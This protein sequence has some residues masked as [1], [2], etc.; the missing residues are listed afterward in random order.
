MALEDEV[1]RHYR[2]GALEPA[3]LDALAAAGKNLDKLSLADLAPVDEFHLGGRA[4]TVALAERLAFVPGT[5]L[6][7]IGCGIGGP[8]RYF[9]SAHGCR[10]TGIDLSAEFVAVA[11]ALAQRVGLADKVIYRQTSALALPFAAASFD[12]ATMFHVGMN[13]EDKPKLFAEVRRVLKPS[14]R[15]GINDIMRESAEILAYPTPWAAGEATSFLADAATYERLLQAAGFV[16]E[17]VSNRR[18]FALATVRQVRERAAH[19]RQPLGIV[20]VIG[21]NAP[22]RI[23]NMMSGVQRGVIAPV[24]IIARAA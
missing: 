24:E 12:A 15:F 10:V 20:Q 17:A 18:D 1:A 6:L 3:L 16:I 21:A 7:D 8:S 4:A 14:G 9:A 11:A 13:I 2:H 19:G 22:Q 5:E 23:A